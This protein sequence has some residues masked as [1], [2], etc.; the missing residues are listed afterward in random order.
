[1]TKSVYVHIPFCETIC[2]YCDFCKFYYNEEMADVYLEALEKEIIDNYNDEL[3]ETIYIGG[4]TPTSLTI[5]QLK[6]LFETIKKLKTN[7]LEYTI[8][9]NIEN[10]NEEKLVLFKEYGINRISVG[11]QT[12]SEKALKYL[13]RNHTKE[14]FEKIK[15]IKK[16]INNINVDL[17]YAIPNQTL[18]DLENDVNLILELNISHI[19]TYSLIIEDHTILKNNGVNNIDEELDFEMYKLICNKFKDYEHYEISNFGKIKSNHNLTYWNNE[20]YFG[21][22]LGASGYINDVRYD[23]TKSFNSYIRGNYRLT[24]EYQTNVIKIENEFILGLRKLEGI[25][26]NIFKEKYNIDVKDIKNV[27]EL[28]NAKKLIL[29]DDKLFISQEYIYTSNDILINFID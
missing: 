9:C 2:S 29:E 7:N 14:V 1:M 4:G 16:Y 6:Q 28:I 22:G 24:E 8:E 20:E 26:I 3:I 25:N 11:I 5:K 13:N 10:I 23:N 19:S 21:F 17:I 18:E 15:I 12:F 27:N